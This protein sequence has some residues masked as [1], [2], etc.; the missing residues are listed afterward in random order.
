LASTLKV[1][2]QKKSDNSPLSIESQDEQTRINLTALVE[3]CKETLMDVPGTFVAP[4]SRLAPNYFSRWKDEILVYNAKT[5]FLTFENVLIPGQYTAFNVR[6]RNTWIEIPD[7][8]G[9]ELQKTLNFSLFEYG[10]KHSVM[11]NI[12]FGREGR[13]R[14][15]HALK[16]LSTKVRPLKDQ[17]RGKK[18]HGSHSVGEVGKSTENPRFGKKFLDPATAANVVKSSEPIQISVESPDD[19][20]PHVNIHLENIRE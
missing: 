11:I 18:S 7:D 19:M 8:F 5:G 17:R 14:W 4:S 1:I 20:L 13:S 10:R 12:P 9:I 2:A 15:V 16:K 6:G 3:E